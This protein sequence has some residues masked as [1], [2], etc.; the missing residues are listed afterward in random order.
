V[1]TDDLRREIRELISGID[2]LDATEID[3]QASVLRWIDSGAPLFREQGATPPI[4]LAVYFAFLD[5]ERH[6]LLQVDHVKAGA[7]LLPG[8]HVD[9]ESPWRS[10][11]READEELAVRAAFHPVFG[12]APLFVTESVTRGP[13]SHTDVTLWYV[14]D[15]KEGMAL[16]GDEREISATRWVGLDAVDTWVNDCFAPD[17]I[18]RFVE[19]MTQTLRRAHV[20]P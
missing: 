14:L 11:L 8:G 10:V 16:E 2:P 1:T 13:M 18:A 12:D 19:K 4:H 9:A 5:E 3:A 17:Q 20:T 15:G 6:S 7:W